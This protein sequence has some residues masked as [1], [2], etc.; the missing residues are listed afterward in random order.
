MTIKTRG[1]IIRSMKYGETSLIV[2]VLTEAKGLRTYIVSGVRQSKSKIGAALL[3]VPSL[4]ELEAYERENTNTQ[5]INR[6]REIKSAYI[7]QKIPFEVQRGAVA[8]FLAEVIRRVIRED[9][10]DGEHEVMFRFLFEAFL[11][12]DTTQYSF[13]NLP[14]GFLVTLSHFLGFLPHQNID[15]QAVTEGGIFE[16]FDMK[17]GVF[18]REMIGHHDFMNEPQTQLFKQL[19]QT[20]FFEVHKLRFNR[21][22]RQELLKNLIL[23]YSI[24]IE[25][26]GKINAHLI[27]QEIF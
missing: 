22:E 26:M 12:L 6:L 4:V 9:G 8:L 27:L 24:H 13:A 10:I 11:F 16:I 19:L 3:Q 5:K 20:S 17:D 7:F 14:L 2:D 15:N 21:V 18:R 1:I 25:Q 23:F